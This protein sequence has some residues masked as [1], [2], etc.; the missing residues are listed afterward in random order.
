[1][2]EYTS[3]L[4]LLHCTLYFALCPLLKVSILT[5]LRL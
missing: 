5:P 4:P 2:A 1:V 3:Q